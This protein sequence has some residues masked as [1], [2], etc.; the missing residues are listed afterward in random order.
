MSEQASRLTIDR[1]APREPPGR[2]WSIRRTGLFA[3]LLAAFLAVSLPALVLT[4]VLLSQQ[5]GATFGGYATVSSENTARATVNSVELWM[6]ER[7]SDMERLAVLLPA[8]LRDPGLGHTLAGVSSGSSYEVVEVTDPAGHVLAASDGALAFDASSQDWL[9]A[10]SQA[11]VIRPP[12]VVQEHIRWIQAMPVHGADG[13]LQGLIVANLRLDKLDQLLATLHQDLRIPSQLEV[14]GTDHLLLYSSA[15][16]VAQD[17][18]TLLGQGVL[19]TRVDTTPVQLALAGGSG[20]VRYTN[21][22]GGD[23]LAGYDVI[24]GTGWGVVDEQ[25]AGQA[26]Q[27]ISDGVR[28]GVVAAVAGSL[29]ALGAGVLVARSVAGPLRALSAAA[30]HVGDG[31]L[32]TRVRPSGAAELRRLGEAFNAMAERM[33][34]STARMRTVGRDLGMGSVQLSTASEQLVSTATDQS[35]AST[36]TSTSMEELVRAAASIAETMGKVAGQ[37]EQTREYLQETGVALD[38]SSRRTG[39]LGQRVN[40]IN[41]ILALINEIADQ[42]NLLSLNAAIEAA[43]AG[44]AGRGFSVVAEEVRR[45]A[46]RSKTSSAEIG[47]IISSTQTEAAATVMAMEAS[48]RHMGRS[49]EL[50]EEV[51]EASHQVEQITEQQR[52]ATEQAVEAIEQ[53][54]RGNQQVLDTAKGLAEAAAAQASLAEELQHAT[55]LRPAD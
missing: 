15:L 33:Q 26:L 31:R 28:T 38:E 53:V 4:T 51:T 16:A 8:Q 37:A 49:L 27:A 39:A 3:R 13:V 25:D 32:D 24:N 14:V 20:S 29:L 18:A 36:E 22:A 6:A 50:V 23:R 11:Y 48:S 54:S 5:A 35:A 44:D 41:A 7:K 2:S 9:G 19:R 17:A 12:A 47:Q 30:V 21:G 46:E 52:L 45:L 10:A 42:T 40:E 43:R 34:A 1:A 55:D